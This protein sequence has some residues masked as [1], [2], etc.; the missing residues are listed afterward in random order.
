MHDHSWSP[1]DGDFVKH[2]PTAAISVDVLRPRRSVG[3]DGESGETRELPIY[4]PTEEF[5]TPVL[6]TE[7]PRRDKAVNGD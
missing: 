7:V 3:P 2:C 4:S 6:G 5:P 1:A